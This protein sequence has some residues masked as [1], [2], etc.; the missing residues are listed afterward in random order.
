MGRIYRLPLLRHPPAS[1]R[2][3]H[4]PLPLLP[5]LR[6]RGE[7][8]K[9]FLTTAKAE[10]PLPIYEKRS[11]SVTGTATGSDEATRMRA[12]W[13]KKKKKEEEEKEVAGC[14]RKP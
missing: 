9:A 7:A 2:I 5:L 12:T 3:L 14:C 10:D 1:T 13:R 11:R 6:L 4:L 8:G